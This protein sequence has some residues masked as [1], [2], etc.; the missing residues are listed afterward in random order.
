MELFW[1]LLIVSVASLIKGITGF[2]FALVALPPLLIWYTPVQII[3]VLLLCNL[4]SS[5]IIVLQKKD[6]ALV[7]PE[8]KTLIIWGGLFSLMGAALLKYIPENIM[9]RAISVV[10]IVLTLLSIFSFKRTVRISK[11]TYKIS[12]GLIGFLTGAV[13]VSGPP[14][15]LLLNLTKVSNRE[16]RE[17][18]SWFNIVT[19]VVAIA[20][21]LGMGLLTHETIKT[22]VLFAPILYMGSFIGKRINSFIPGIIFRNATLAITLVSC[23]VLLIR[24]A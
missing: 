1:I 14:L 21:Y 2:G 17:I 5:V 4:L 13:S 20:G 12:G 3:P 15:A 6:Q 11:L 18:F 9:I 22:V 7:K 10:F 8:Y 23:I 19:S 24:T 16:F